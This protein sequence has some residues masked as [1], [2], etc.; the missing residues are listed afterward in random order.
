[1]FLGYAEQQRG[2]LRE[3]IAQYQKALDVTQ[4]YGRS[5]AR[6]RSAAFES[7]GYSYR[8]LGDYARAAQCLQAAQELSRP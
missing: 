6:V 5:A 1:L 3:A 2:H 7:M 4:S 8:A